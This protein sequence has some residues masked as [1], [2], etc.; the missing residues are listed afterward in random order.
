[1]AY[2]T[3]NSLAERL[4]VTRPTISRLSK[5]GDFPRP[6]KVGRQLRFHPDD[7]AEWERQQRAGKTLAVQSVDDSITFTTE[8]K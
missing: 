1:M 5:A 8:G 3:L 4:G 7:V 2:F 6:I